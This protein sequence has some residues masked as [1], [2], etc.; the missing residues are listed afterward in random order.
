MIKLKGMYLNH[1]FNVVVGKQCRTEMRRRVTNTT[2]LCKL[3]NFLLLFICFKLVFLIDENYLNFNIY[4]N[5][6]C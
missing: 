1:D 3:I 2:Y 6:K 5:V 4:L